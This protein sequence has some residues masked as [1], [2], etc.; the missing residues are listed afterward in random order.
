MCRSYVCFSKRVVIV[1]NVYVILAICYALV[2]VYVWEFQMYIMWF[3]ISVYCTVIVTITNNVS[4]EL[5]LKINLRR[6]ENNFQK[7]L[8]FHLILLKFQQSV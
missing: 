4:N 6:S 5:T 7:Y 3:S 1:V 8:D 2:N